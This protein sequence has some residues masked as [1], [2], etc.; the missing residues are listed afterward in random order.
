MPKP[1]PL[2]ESRL[3]TSFAAV[4]TAA[5]IV[6]TSARSSAIMLMESGDPSFHASTPGDNSGWQYEGKFLTFLGVPIAPHFF[7]TAKHIGGVVGNTF[8]FHG[9]LYTTIAKHPSPTTDLCI[10]EVDHAKPFPT[11]APLS[12]GSMDVGA[13][14]TV[15]G[16][17]TQRGTAVMVSSVLK[18]W[19]WGPSDDVKRW[20]RNVVAGTVT[21]PTYGQLLYCDF[22]WPGIPGECHMSV[23][24]SGGGLFVL[25]NGLWRLAGINLA[26]DGPFRTGPTDPS[27]SGALFDLGGLEYNAP[28]WTPIPDQTQ[29]IP[30]SFYCSR[31]SASLSWISTTAPGSNSIPQESYEAWQKLYFSPSQIANPGLS[32]KSSDFDGDGIRNLLEFALHLDPIFAENAPMIPD[33]GIRG[34]PHGRIVDDNGTPRLALEFVRRDASSGAGL[35]YLVEFSQDLVQWSGGG[36]VSTESINSRWER[37]KTLDPV[38]ATTSPGRYV[39]LRVVSSP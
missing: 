27:F 17:G 3:G 26:V 29:D 4:L 14:A 38:S 39:R 11:Y 36:I 33:T 32:G 35:T 28:P 37:V 23:G 30:S 13:T 12:S 19:K 9:D 34:L 22:D 5:A 31:I 7:I 1:S 6:A 15:F 24:D 25:E 16:R 18:G 2:Q 8:D 10:W 21:D 20:G